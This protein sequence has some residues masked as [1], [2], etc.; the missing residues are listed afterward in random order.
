MGE[1][2]CVYV[3]EM[4]Q[5]F[6]VFFPQYAVLRE[7]VQSIHERELTEFI[8]LLL[9]CGYKNA[10]ILSTSLN[11]KQKYKHNYKKY[12]SG[13]QIK[14]DA[15]FL[16]KARIGDMCWEGAVWS[17]GWNYLKNVNLINNRKI[18]EFHVIFNQLTNENYQALPTEMTNSFVVPGIFLMC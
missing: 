6:F 17:Q 4:Y 12:S 18:I 14:K 3:T 13:N 11:I 2:K 10:S 7:T 15:C 8:H 1:K 5:F 16:W 9:K